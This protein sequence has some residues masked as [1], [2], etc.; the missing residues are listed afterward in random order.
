[1]IAGETLEF[2][3]RLKTVLF[4][5]HYVRFAGHHLKVFDYFN[6]VLAAPGHTALIRF[7]RESKLDA[8]NPWRAFESHVVRGKEVVQADAY[9]FSGMDWREL[10]PD[11][12]RDPRVP[13]INYVQSI[14]H[15]WP[16]NLRYAL[17]RNRAI[18]ICVSP[19]VAE[20]IAGTGLVRGPLFTIQAAI[21]VAEVRS[22]RRDER[23]TDL[24]ILAF[25]EPEL[26]R[27]LAGRLAR[28]GRTIR[29]IDRLV[30][31]AELLDTFARS[32]VTL[33]L[34]HREE[35]KPLPPL[36]GMVLRTVVVCPD[37]VGNRSF[38]LPGVNSFRPPYEEEAI[39]EA[40]ETALGEWANLG[41][42]ITAA[43]RTVREHDLPAER[44]AFLPI[45][46]NL[47]D[48]WEGGDST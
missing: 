11:Q 30:P 16:D 35:G 42:M 40:T 48:L 39:V 6:H 5:R 20:A 22:A 44:G 28:P 1:M 46:Q 8:A 41:E 19:E 23:D 2:P 4:Y 47:D 15:A 31:R 43:E 18:R 25:K 36:E 24:A 45:L 10:P 17:L 21:D 34:L 14:R 37:V 27:S 12:R 13:V 26:G 9:F 3:D 33:F 7:S 32:R 29:L 38:C